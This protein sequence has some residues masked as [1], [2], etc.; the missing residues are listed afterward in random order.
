[1]NTKIALF[2]FNPCVG[3]IKRNTK[4]IIDAA[5]EA[6]RSGAKIIITPELAITGYSPED[7]LFKPAFRQQVSEALAQIEQIDDI[8]IVVGHP[9]W[10]NNQCFNSA[11]VFANG[12]RLGCYQKMLLPNE[13]VFDE[14][15]YFDAGL[16]PLVFE[17][18]NTRYGVLLCED[19]WHTDPAA[20]ALSSGAEVLLALNASPYHPGKLDERLQQSAFRVEET[21]LPLVYVNMNG[22]QDELVFDG[23]SFALNADGSMAFMAKAFESTLDIIELERQADNNKIVIMAD[24]P[25]LKPSMTEEEQLY[26]AV[27]M[28]TRDYVSKNGF[29]RICLGLS[30]GIDSALVLAIAADAI[31]AQNCEVIIMP[32]QYT[33]DI[34]TADA[35]KMAENLQVKYSI[36]PIATL[37]EQ[38]KHNLA[39]RFSGLEGDTTEENIQARIRGTLLM[40]LSNKTGA[41]L[42]NTGNKSELATGYCTLYGDM[43]GGFAVL[44]DLFKT[45]VYALSRYRNRLGLVIPDRII[46]RPPSAELKENQTDQD[47]LPDYP[48]LDAMLAQIMYQNADKQQLC[49]QGFAQTDVERVFKL[50]KISEYKRRQGAIGP[51][52]SPR[53]FGK[54]WRMPVCNQFDG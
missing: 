30:G 16:A 21:G 32:S 51:R 26:R 53:A 38:F 54:D 43:N 29:Q 34:S 28:A 37:F 2:Q 13:G 40:A 4:K 1:M 24:T 7:L 46:D 20:E 31:G 45:Q 12:H 52:V 42:L 11:S 17:W 25:V 48:V 3:D 33:A 47:S 39:E 41:L 35:L 5:Q 50:I 19:L 6:K 14:V 10:S 22:G 23:C 18:E 36:M 9:S 27:V 49:Q 44:K 15:R 8:A